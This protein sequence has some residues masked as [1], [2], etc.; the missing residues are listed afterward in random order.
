MVPTIGIDYTPAYEQGGGIGR[1]VRELMAAL[2]A[3]DQTT[4]YRLFVAGAVG[5]RLPS[6]PAPNFTWKPTRLTPMWLARLW[7]RAR[8]PIP[9][10]V[11]TGQMSLYH[12][13]DFVLP[14][15]RSSTRTLLTVHDLSFVRVPET[16]NPGLRRY[17]DAVVPRSVQRADHVLADSTATKNDLIEIYNTPPEKITVLLSGLTPQFKPV[18]DPAQLRAVRERYHLGETP[19]ILSVG[20]VQPRKN[21]ARLIEALAHLRA[22]KHDVHLVIVGGKGWLEDPIYAALQQHNVEKYVH[23]TGFAAESDLP[24]IYSG[25]LC[26]ALP[27]LYEGFGLPVLEAMGCGIPVVTSAIS[28]LPEVAGDAAILVNPYSVEAIVDALRRIIED[29]T[30]RSHLVD[31]GTA[32]AQTFTWERSAQQ[33]MAL[34]NQMLKQ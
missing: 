4:D 3:L 31:L 32:R 27:S 1:L 18:R 5:S 15:T 26:C 9:V 30:L 10:E 19:Y 28:S 13:T 12:A 23:F 14:P 2:A 11:F 25:A 17:L 22:E 33:L 6:A 7:H 34:Y 29:S 24:A 8:L 16:A 20:T 21:Y